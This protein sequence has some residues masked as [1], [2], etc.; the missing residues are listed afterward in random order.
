M[1]LKN[2]FM[3]EKA[4]FSEVGFF[5]AKNVFKTARKE[6]VTH[7][8]PA[9]VDLPSAVFPMTIFSPVLL[10]KLLK[11][12]KSPIVSSPP[13]SSVAESTLVLLRVNL[14]DGKPTKTPTIASEDIAMDTA[15]IPWPSVSFERK[16]TTLERRKKPL[17]LRRS[18]SSSI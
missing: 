1:G 8:Y 9:V 15:Q 14:H 2:P 4:H 7:S 11:S 13:S 12:H 18:F 6:Q 5:M 17:T 10:P 3:L 16:V